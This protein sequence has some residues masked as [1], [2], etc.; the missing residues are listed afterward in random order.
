VDV[1]RS[2]EISRIIGLPRRTW[3]EQDAIDVAALLTAKLRTPYG[4]HALYPIQGVM[5]AE[6]YDARGL[7]SGA[8][9]GEGKTLPSLLIPTLLGAE[10]PVLLVRAA[11][12]PQTRRDITYWSRHFAVHPGL[13]VVHYEGLSTASQSGVLDM[14]RPDMIIADE[15][16]SLKN[17]DSARGRRFMRYVREHPTTMFFGLSGTI[18]QRSIMDYWHLA[19]LASRDN[20]PLPI[21]Y[22]EAEQWA[23]ALD[24]GVHDDARLAPGALLDLSPAQEDEPSEA[25]D[26]ARRRYRQRLADTVG[27]VMPT[28]PTLGTS[29]LLTRRASEV[30]PCVHSALDKLH[31]TWLTPN[32]DELEWAMD[33]W[34]HA[35]EIA[36]GFW[37][38]WDPPPP[39]EWM[40][41]R[42]AWHAF[43]RQ[44]LSQRRKGLD[45]PLQVAQHYHDHELHTAW[46]AI[47]DAYD[48]EDHKRVEW[49]DDYL[50]VDAARWLHTTPKGIVW[51]EHV[52]VGRAVAER[53]G[54]RYY[55]GGP[56]AADEIADARGPIVC[57]IAAHGTGRNLQDRYCHNLI[58]SCPPS[59]DAVEQLIGRTH[60]LGQTADEVTVELYLQSPDIIDGFA[61][62][63][64]R[65]RYI[66]ATT[67]SRQRVLLAS[68]NFD[69]DN[70]AAAG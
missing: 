20:A 44:I 32:G 23:Q 5:L 52:A 36:S 50:V 43:V 26:R 31:T 48:P 63:I 15:C 41:A 65:A 29:L 59:A 7:L 30:P 22:A 66:L 69:L 64:E 54:V 60:R 18:T 10:R 33:V 57:S 61:S 1:K 68:T 21:I 67:G 11:I 17:R 3:S 28:A 13:R 62:V 46:V 19:L 55:G 9:V 34:R 40:M 47:R 45:S 38:R 4:A 2:A 6:A 27:Y 56:K 70:P 39:T 12:S 35:R 25:I 42:R 16:H 37:Y 51:S 24:P 53:A 8:G 14:I 49:L 58:L